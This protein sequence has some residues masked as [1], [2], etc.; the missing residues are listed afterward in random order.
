MTWLVNVMDG[1]DI[2]SKCS[3][4]LVTVSTSDL[5]KPETFAYG[6]TDSSNNTS[7]YVKLIYGNV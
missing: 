3:D 2:S 6:Y 1:N 5:L 7:G 4:E